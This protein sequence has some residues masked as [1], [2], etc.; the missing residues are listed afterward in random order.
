MVAHFTL[1]KNTRNIVLGSK[2]HISQVKEANR[3]M[4]VCLPLP[5]H[6]EVPGPGIEPA[7]QQGLGPLQWK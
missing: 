3:G 4:F 6:V 7:P 1:V 5:R 2:Y